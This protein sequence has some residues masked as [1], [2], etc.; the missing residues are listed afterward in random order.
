MRIVSRNRL[1]HHEICS[2]KY[3]GVCNVKRTF[4]STQKQLYAKTYEHVDTNLVSLNITTL[5]NQHKFSL[6]KHH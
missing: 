4:N 5:T 1:K 2:Y 6:V 3:K